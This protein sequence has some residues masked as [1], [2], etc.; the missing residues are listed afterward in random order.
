MGV[1]VDADML[2]VKAHFFLLFSAA[3]P[4]T[5]FLPILAKQLG[6]DA[7]GVGIIFAV[8]PFGGMVAKPVAGWLADRLARQ[9][10]VFLLALLLTGGFYFSIQLVSS[11][12]GSFLATFHCSHP[13]SLLKVCGSEGSKVEVLEH[14]S[15]CGEEC[16]VSCDQLTAVETGQLCTAFSDLLPGCADGSPSTSNLQFRLFSNLTRHDSQPSPSCLLLPGDSYSTSNSSTTSTNTSSTTIWPVLCEERVEVTC[17]IH[18]SNPHLQEMARKDSIFSSPMFWLF[19]LL[20]LVSYSCFTTAATISDAICF[21]KLGA[22]GDQ[23]GQQRVWGS[24]GW[25]LFT[26][27]AGYLVDSSS[28]STSTSLDY[29]PAFL[30]MGGLMVLDLLA[31]SYIKIPEAQRSSRV[32]GEVAEQVCNPRELTFLAWCLSCGVLTSII[33]QWLLWYLSD[34]ATSTSSSSSATSSPDWVT[35]LLGINMAV[36]CFVGEVPMFFLSG[37]ILRHLGHSATMTLVL[38]AFSLRFF[39]YSLLSDP[40]LSLPIELLNG[41]TFGLCYS[42]MTSYAHSIATPG[43]EATMQGVVGAMFEGLGVAIGSFIGGAVYQHSGGKVLFQS[44]SALALV[45]CLL[46]LLLTCTIA[47]P[48]PKVVVEEEVQ[49]ELLGE[50]G[51]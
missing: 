20:N 19:F 5:P 49:G 32:W 17:S 29:T 3:A 31:A 23:Y 4:V 1:K 14:L 33:W 6:I 35:T 46:H 11:I 51:I 34:L 24:I 8:L 12:P 39:L 26:V 18:C 25:G 30:L 44:F 42:T 16:Q 28:S 13:F 48:K 10:L 2:P 7:F 43:T 41:V 27:V 15:S 36:Q 47:R 38:G 9:R 40:W 37:W 22:R 45:L 21:D 50:E